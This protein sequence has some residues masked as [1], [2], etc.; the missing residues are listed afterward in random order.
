MGELGV[1]WWIMDLKEIRFMGVYWN[2]LDQDTTAQL[3]DLM[4]GN[5]LS[6]SVIYEEFLN[7]LRHCQ[8]HK[9][10]LLCNFIICIMYFVYA[11]R[12]NLRI[13][14]L[15]RDSGTL[16]ILCFFVC[17]LEVDGSLSRHVLLHCWNSTF[18]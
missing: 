9:N 7:H 1:D 15:Y 3:W 4:H 13:I 18:G 11:L 16:T 17:A 2:L 10:D 8:F 6:G 5:E 12:Q 14:D